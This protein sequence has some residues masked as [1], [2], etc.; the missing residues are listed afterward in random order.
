MGYNLPLK[1]SIIYFSLFAYIF[2][3]FFSLIVVEINFFMNI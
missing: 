3:Q 2:K 1:N